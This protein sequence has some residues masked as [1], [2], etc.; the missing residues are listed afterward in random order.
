[1]KKSTNVLLITI[2]LSMGL[3]SSCNKTDSNTECE[4]TNI[5]SSKGLLITETSELSE[6][7]ISASSGTNVSDDALNQGIKYSYQLPS[8]VLNTHFYTDDIEVEVI[9]KEID[10]NGINLFENDNNEQKIYLIF[11][12]E[13]PSEI[14]ENVVGHIPLVNYDTSSEKYKVVGLSYMNY[15]FNDDGTEDYLVKASIANKDSYEYLLSTA[16]YSF[17]RIFLTSEIGYTVID[18][19]AFN[20]SRNCCKFVLSTMTNGL[21]DIFVFCNSNSP[22]LSYDGISGYTGAK[23]LDERHTFLNAE[24]LFE[25][26]LHINMKISSID[27]D[28][29][30]YYTAIKFADNQYLTNNLLYSCYPDGKPHSYIKKPYG[31]DERIE[32]NPSQEGYD[33]Y[34]ELTDEGVAA[35]AEEDNVWRLL[36]LLEIK[37]IAAD[38][39]NT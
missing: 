17:E 10:T 20:D 26:V 7:I 18:L 39:N 3:M 9:Y 23:E 24:I 30:E 22:I 8:E 33:F 5:S 29:G 12:Q 31:D 15:D 21:N 4:I 27:A 34:V 11:K 1:M 37:Y 13:L 32:F 35:F 16:F 25:N 2:L 38:K 19:P 28:K 6:N 14:V 36:E